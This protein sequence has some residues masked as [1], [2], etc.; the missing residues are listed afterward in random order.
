MPSCD[1]A[2]NQAYVQSNHAQS[3]FQKHLYLLA[4]LV[5]GNCQK[6]PWAVWHVNPERLVQ[7]VFIHFFSDY[8]YDQQVSNLILLCTSRFQTIGS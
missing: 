7:S 2:K 8:S 3:L 5:E 4:I 6:Q 1:K